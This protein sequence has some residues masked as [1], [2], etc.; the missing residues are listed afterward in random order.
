MGEEQVIPDYPTYAITQEGYVRDLR[1][2]ELKDGH[3]CNGYRR[4]NLTN[5]TG[6][7]LISIHRLVGL[8]FI[9]NPDNLPEIDHIDRNPANNRVEN[10]RWAN[11]F[12]QN[13]N[14]GNQK[15]NI[16]GYKNISCE[17]NYFR[18]L[19]T[20][21]GKSIVRKRFQHLKDAVIFRDEMY[22]SHN[23]IN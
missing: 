13:Q 9:P 10:L 1:T 8:T 16:S 11:D 4:I 19:I 5:P 15:N 6:S 17:D 3:S 18:V 7:K 23:I 21:N 22:K 20:R 14:K 12:T 2:G